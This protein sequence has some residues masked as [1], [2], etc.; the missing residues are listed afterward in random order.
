LDR[1]FT[2]SSTTAAAVSSH[3]VS[4]PKILILIDY[5]LGD[6]PYAKGKVRFGSLFLVRSFYDSVT[7]IDE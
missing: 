2:P 3:D 7:L 4:I 1:I 6:V 5:S